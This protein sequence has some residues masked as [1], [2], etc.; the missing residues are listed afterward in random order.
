MRLLSRRSLPLALLALALTGP[1]VG[2]ASADSPSHADAG[3]A[4]IDDNTAGTN[5]IAGFARAADGSLTALPGSPFSAGGSGL[6][7]GVGSQGAIQ[8]TDNGRLLLAV[9]AGSNQVSVLR[10][11]HDGSLELVGSPVASGGVKPVSIAIHRHLVYVANA[12]NVVSGANYTGFILHHGQLT[13][14]ADSTV[15]LSPTAAPGDVLFN[16]DG[17]KLVGA[18]VGP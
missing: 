9:D 2:S 6:G 15:A 18:E 7:K 4:Y 17:T 11:E 5:T 12:G 16:G 1:A 3:H 13:P 8:V 14:L 10:I